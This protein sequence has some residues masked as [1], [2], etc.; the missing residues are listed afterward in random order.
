MNAPM[1][2]VLPTPVASAKQKDGNSRSKSV[3]VGNSQRRISSAAAMSGPLCG[4]MISVM[5]SR[6]S[7]ERRCGAR[8][9]NR[10]AMALTLGFILLEHY[11]KSLVLFEPLNGPT[12][13]L[14]GNV[15]ALVVCGLGFQKIITLFLHHFVVWF[16]IDQCLEKMPDK[17]A[18]E[19]I[20]PLPKTGF[21]S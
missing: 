12:P 18:G 13:F 6:I 4:G 15:H 11:E 10:P 17:V 14:V 21:H 19:V 7:S 16:H 20:D 9:L 2:R 5:R 1:S 8:K 3:T